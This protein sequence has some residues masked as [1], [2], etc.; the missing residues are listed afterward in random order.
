ML[1]LKRGFKPIIV[2]TDRREGPGM[3]YPKTAQSVAE[4]LAALVQSNDYAAAEAKASAEVHRYLS[5]IKPEPASTDYLHLRRE[6]LSIFN[7]IAEPG[8][9]ADKVA[10]AI[11][12]HSSQR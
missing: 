12:G 6:L 5:S 7:K 8:R 10:A 11:E 1:S 3:N 4:T 9:L 2:S